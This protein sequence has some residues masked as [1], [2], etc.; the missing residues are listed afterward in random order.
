MT[1]EN[2]TT[3]L[4]MDPFSL[5]VFS[6]LVGLA[7]MI[8]GLAAFYGNILFWYLTL[9]VCFV[10]LINSVLMVPEGLVRFVLILIVLSYLT[11]PQVKEHYGIGDEG[12]TKP[13]SR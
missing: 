7:L 2:E 9:A 12:S 1:I 5:G 10:A 8:C 11:R 3:L 13:Y 6:L 4:G